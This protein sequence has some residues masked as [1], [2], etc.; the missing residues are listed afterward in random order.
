MNSLRRAVSS[1]LLCSARWL[2]IGSCIEPLMDF[3]PF[4]EFSSLSRVTNIPRQ[5]KAVCANATVLLD[6]AI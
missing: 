4:P 2:P 5:I 6:R 3:V 1:W